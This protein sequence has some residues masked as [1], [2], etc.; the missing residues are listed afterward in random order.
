MDFFYEGRF[1]D[2]LKDMEARYIHPDVFTYNIIINAV[3]K[4]E[5]MQEIFSTIF[6]PK[7]CDPMLTYISM[8][9]L[10]FTQIDFGLYDLRPI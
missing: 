10:G 5:D 3:K 6:L 1:T 2:G 7:A 9:F 4:L 8:F